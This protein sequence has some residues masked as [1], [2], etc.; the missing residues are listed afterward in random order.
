MATD[1]ESNPALPVG[2]LPGDPVIPVTSNLALKWLACPAPGVIG[3]D[4]GLAGSVYCGWV[5]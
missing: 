2:F 1:P 4:L 3:S 5:R